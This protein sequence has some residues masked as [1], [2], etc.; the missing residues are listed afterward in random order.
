MSTGVR[1]EEIVNVQDDN[2]DTLLAHVSKALPELL[3]TGVQVTKHTRR[4]QGERRALRLSLD[5]SAIE[6]FN[7]NPAFWRK[8]LRIYHLSTLE[9]VGPA[10]SIPGG[11]PASP[12]RTLLFR[13][14]NH[15]LFVTARTRATGAALVAIFRQGSCLKLVP[16]SGQ[17]QRP[18]RPVALTRSS[19][20]D[21]TTTHSSS[22]SMAQKGALSME[23]TPAQQTATGQQQGRRT[24]LSPAPVRPWSASS[25]ASAPTPQFN[26]LEMSHVER[27]TWRRCAS[28]AELSSNAYSTEDSGVGDGRLPG[29]APSP[30]SSSDDGVGATALAGFMPS[31]TTSP[32]L[33]FGAATAPATAATAATA[34]GVE[35]WKRDEFQHRP[36]PPSYDS[37]IRSNNAPAVATLLQGRNSSR[38]APLQARAKARV[39]LERGPPARSGGGGTSTSTSSGSSGGSR[40]ELGAKQQNSFDSH[41][42]GRCQSTAMVN[43]RAL[44]MPSPADSGITVA[45]SPPGSNR[46]PLPAPFTLSPDGGGSCSSSPSPGAAIT[47]TTTAMVSVV[48]V[49]D[50]AG[51]GTATVALSTPPPPA[52]KSARDVPGARGSGSG[53]SHRPP[54]PHVG[55]DRRALPRDHHRQSPEMMHKEVK[56]PPG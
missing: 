31:P 22:R 46:E 37:V 30:L 50:V 40:Q 20:S 15:N 11:L 43:P 17:R 21:I 6:V 41:R 53:L 25:V 29:S 54:M 47:A 5:R 33:G 51:P 18:V 3:G 49:T 55:L 14:S 39:P 1:R 10:K 32:L 24:P 38:L 13:F 44:S 16:P 2:Q 7:T 8:P 26:V 36:P 4:G 27:R 45:L 34:A 48:E 28:S 52:A 12:G 56:T 9:E 42:A 23:G 19:S 35:G